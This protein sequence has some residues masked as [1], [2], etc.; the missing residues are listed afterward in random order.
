MNDNQPIDDDARAEDDDQIIDLD[1]ELRAIKMRLARL[2]RAA[3]LSEVAG[4][5][6]HD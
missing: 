2:E 5:E 6:T 4:G 3:G 1:A